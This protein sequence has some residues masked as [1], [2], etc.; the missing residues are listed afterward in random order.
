M[1][2][3]SG[4]VHGCLDELHELLRKVNFTYGLDVLLFTGDLGNR[5]PYSPQVKTPF[6]LPSCTGH[7]TQ[8]ANMHMDTP[9]RCRSI[10]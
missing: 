10:P 7:M 9:C 5:G 1:S 8:L 4:D 2:V 6:S 3:G